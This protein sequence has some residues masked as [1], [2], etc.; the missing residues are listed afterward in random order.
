MHVHMLQK[1]QKKLLK[2]FILYK[3]R[4]ENRFN[5]VLN[6]LELINEIYSK[7]K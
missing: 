4:V 1:K 7:N 5:E 6:L 3:L 2:I